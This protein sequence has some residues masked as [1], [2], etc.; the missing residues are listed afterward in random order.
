MFRIDGDHVSWLLVVTLVALAL[1]LA[2]VSSE[3]YGGDRVAGYRGD[4]VAGTGAAPTVRLL[5]AQQDRT[6]HRTVSEVWYVARELYRA[7]RF[8]EAAREFERATAGHVADPALDMW[9]GMAA[10][11]AGDVATAMRHWRTV[12]CDG[13]MSD[14]GVWPGVALAAAYVKSGQVAE[15]ARL[16]VPLERGDF[17]PEVAEQPLVTFYAALAYDQ[18][19]ATAPKYRDSIE[20]SLAMK[21]SPPLASSDTGF[22]VSPNSQSWLIFLAKRAY[23]R[24]IRNSKTFEWTAPLVP[25]SATAEPSLTPTVEELLE[26]LGS[27]DFNAQARGKLR[28]IRLFES[29]PKR[30]EIFDDPDLI[31]RGR[32]IA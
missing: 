12:W 2:L 7:G 29:A 3:G 32:F 18:L 19:A 5:L 23:Q 13:P 20:E 9:A 25:E 22:A 26:S 17:G 1:L 14:A 15:A 28:A 6:E 16:I 4:L 27:A 10:Y 21:F 24:T 30:I 31:K 11:R 8:A